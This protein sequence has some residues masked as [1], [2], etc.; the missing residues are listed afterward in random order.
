MAQAYDLVHLVARAAEIERSLA[1]G[2]IRDGL[3]RIPEHRGLVKTYRPP[4]TPGRHEALDA[5]DLFLG[6]FDRH[7]KIVPVER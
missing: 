6:Q 3:E 2:R 4:F 1:P 7:G 5:D